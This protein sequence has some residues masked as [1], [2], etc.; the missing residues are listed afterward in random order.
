M[1]NADRPRGF[2]PIRMVDGGAAIP[3]GRYAVDSS[4]ATAIFIGDL[5]TLEADGNVGIEADT[6]AANPLGVCV[7][8]DDDF[9]NLA[10]RY[11]PA[12]T[13]GNIFVTDSPD[14]IYEAQE[15][16]NMLATTA[17]GANV[18]IVAGA[19]ST[20]TS[21]SAYE[22]DSDSAATTT[23]LPI[24]VLRAVP[25]EDNDITLTNAD[26]EVLINTHVYRARGGVTGEGV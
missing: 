21:I 6:T 1:A 9:D 15:D 4:N 26:F 24:R 11:L 23:T 22:L 7:G 12:S 14:T 8:V 19:G 5:V 18:G 2:I 25:R 16:G 10:R 13:A 17:I 3:V 20:T